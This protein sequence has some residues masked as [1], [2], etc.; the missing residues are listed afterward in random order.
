M[1]GVLLA[2]NEAV[3]LEHL[4]YPM[5]MSRKYDGNRL[6]ILNGELLSRSLK[7]QPNQNLPRHLKDLVALSIQQGLVFDGELYDHDLSFPELQSV[8]RSFSQKITPGMKYY[9]FD[10]L[11]LSEWNSGK[12]GTFDHRQKRYHS[13]LFKY[14]P[15]HTEAVEQ[16]WVTSPAKARSLYQKFLREGFEG[17]ILRDPRGPYKH[18]R[19][20]VREGI[21][22]KLKEFVTIDACI[23][24]FTQRRRMKDTV[25]EG[26]R[27]RDAMGHLEQ[28][29]R[30]DDYEFTN[31]VGT[32]I[33]RT[34]EGAEVGVGWAEGMKGKG[35]TI[36]WKRRKEF[37]GK[38]VEIR[39]MRHG[40]KDLPRIG[41]IVRFRPDLD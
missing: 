15:R 41:A 12:A 5:L 39:Y 20:T 9:V 23:T 26:N 10:V 27:T 30:K 34:A 40:M 21:M 35:L 14:Q 1:N 19:A 24:G 4:V 18:G 37:L 38:H 32:V 8:V 3:P 36:S 17:G 11:T 2:P 16:T 7:P 31:E 13:L 22:F 25:R 29:H 6:L 33:V 28:S